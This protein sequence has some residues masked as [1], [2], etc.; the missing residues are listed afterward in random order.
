MPLNEWQPIAREILDGKHDENLDQID[1]AVKYR[2][3]SMFRAGAK[4]KLVGTKN[5]ELDGQIA[6]V[7]R[8][9]TKRIAVGV[10]E[11]TEEYGF[12]TWSVG[13]YNVPAHMLVAV[14]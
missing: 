10:G 7:I 3:K 13:E 9:N 6:T 8:V 14:S 4:F 1:Q 12:K 11:Q 5:P 2:K